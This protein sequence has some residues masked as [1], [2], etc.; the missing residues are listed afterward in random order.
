[1]LRWGGSARQP[2]AC[3]RPFAVTEREQAEHR[4]SI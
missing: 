1:M 2:N 4:C 3:A